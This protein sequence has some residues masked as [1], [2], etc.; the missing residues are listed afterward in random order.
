MDYQNLNF[1]NQSLLNMMTNAE[2]LLKDLD[3]IW[4]DMHEVENHLLNILFSE[5]N[6]ETKPEVILVIH[7]KVGEENSVRKYEL[8]NSRKSNYI[9]RDEQI[10]YEALENYKTNNNYVTATSNG[11]TVLA[12]NFPREHTSLYQEIIKGFLV[13]L[14]HFSVIYEQTEKIKES[15]VYTTGALARASEAVD[16]ETGYHIQRVSH[17]S[18]TLARELNFSDK[19]LFELSYSSKMHDVGKIKVPQEVLLKPG[20][21]DT[22]EFMEME[23]HTIY[24]V[25][26]LG[27]SQHLKMARDIALSHHEKY[28]GSG[29][30]NGLSGEEIP[31]SARIVALADVYDA[32]RSERPYK[33]AFDHDTACEII[34][35][36]DDRLT[37]ESFCPKVLR[38]FRENVD[39][40]AK[41][42]HDMPDDLYR[43][44]L[45]N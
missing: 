24:G 45:D 10:D 28:D 25:L 6:F 41:I 39:E 11:I 35:E 14:A 36:G 29:Y 19:A 1:F 9:Y 15:F 7:P 26:I 20:R 21:L 30:P 40:F 23:N 38:V 4:I 32:L 17:Y 43:F 18:L 2:K 8:K 33:P 34:L 5:A 44:D 22:E 42:Y 3:P 27:D 37:P 31:L 13:Q 12:T 16:S